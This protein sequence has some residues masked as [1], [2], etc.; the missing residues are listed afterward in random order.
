MQIIPAIDIRGGRC[1]RLRQGDYDA[2]TVFDDDPVAAAQ[3]WVDAGAQR[4]HVVDLD[5][6]RDGAPANF[7]LV[8]AIAKL[9]LPTQ[10]GGGIRDADTVR[11]YLDAGLDR[12]VLGTAAVRDANLIESLVADCGEALIVSLDAR[13]GLIATDGWTE[14]SDLQASD[15]AAR[16]VAV[17]VRRFVYTDINRDGMLDEPNYAAVQRLVREVGVPVIAAGGVADKSHIAPLAA[18][19]A[20]AVIVGRALYDG[21]L[22]LR[23]AL[24]EAERAG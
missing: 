15:L 4:L 22:D 23:E 5:G 11:R 1:V 2:E 6:A 18:T 17:G 9:G 24:Q 14:T 8:T 16:L 13:D 7:D 12:V 21:R 19:G 20:E 10:T 3:R